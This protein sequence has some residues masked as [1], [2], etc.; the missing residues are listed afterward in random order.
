M[1]EKQKMPWP[2]WALALDI[3]GAVF[4]ALGLIAMFGASALD[5]PEIDQFRSWAIPLIVLGVLLMV[6]L[7]YFTIA[8]IRSSK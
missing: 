3:V 6:P 7:V 4:F 8:S 1:A 5:I 2:A